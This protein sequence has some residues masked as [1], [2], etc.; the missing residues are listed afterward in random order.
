MV[1]AIS[2]LIFD[3]VKGVVGGGV[4]PQCFQMSVEFS[5]FCNFQEGLHPVQ[6]LVGH[7]HLHQVFPYQCMIL[8]V[9]LIHLAVNR[10]P[11]PAPVQ[12]SGGGSM[13]GGLGSTIAQGMAFGTGSA[14]AHRAVDAVMG[15][16]TI[17]HETVAPE[18]TAAPAST[19]SSFGGSDACGMHTKAFQDCLNSSGNDISKCQFYMD[20]LSDCRRN[21]GSMMSA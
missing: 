9:L 15:P 3:P 1:G 16:R 10:A 17:Q 20:M 21:S 19:T 18:A 6:L 11:P 13:L 2:G 8:L 14:V 12:S 5:I 4:E 7:Q